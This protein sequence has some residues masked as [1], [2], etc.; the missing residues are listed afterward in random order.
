[1]GGQTMAARLFDG[2]PFL[3]L[4]RRC[5]VR[6]LNQSWPQASLFKSGR[7]KPKL[8]NLFTKLFS[9]R[10]SLNYEAKP[11]NIENRPWLNIF[12]K[13]SPRLVAI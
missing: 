8:S 4:A 3:G 11:G 6:K 12:L 2:V 13:F 9:R 1:M 10:N 5:Q 7:S